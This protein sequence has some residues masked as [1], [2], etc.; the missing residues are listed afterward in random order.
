VKKYGEE[1][2]FK[3]AV[4]ARRGAVKHMAGNFD[5]GAT[6]RKKRMSRV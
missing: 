2:A 5:P 6:R 3:L 4:K 1:G